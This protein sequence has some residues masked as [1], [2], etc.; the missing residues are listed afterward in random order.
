M[1]LVPLKTLGIC[2]TAPVEPVTVPQK[3]C[4]TS[5]SEST[6]KLASPTMEGHFRGEDTP[7]SKLDPSGCPS[8]ESGGGLHLGFAAGTAPAQSKALSTSMTSYNTSSQPCHLLWGH[9]VSMERDTIAQEIE[10]LLHLWDRYQETSEGDAGT[11]KHLAAREARLLHNPQGR[12]HERAG[13][14]CGESQVGADQL[15]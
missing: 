1:V 12:P 9:K 11:S 3:L 5:G 10:Y 6:A 7:A 2:F 13:Q 8:R 4:L 14:R 15:V